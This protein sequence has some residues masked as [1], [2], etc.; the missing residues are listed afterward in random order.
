M[1]CFNFSKV[2]FVPCLLLICLG[3]S[4][5]ETAAPAPAQ[6]QAASSLS[7]AAELEGKME[8]IASDPDSVPTIVA[9]MRHC[10]PASRLLFSPILYTLVANL[11]TPR[12][13]RERSLAAALV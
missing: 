6:V 3:C 1:G 11:S 12:M 2:W 8:A 13:G 9:S 4:P 5:E 7:F 10:P